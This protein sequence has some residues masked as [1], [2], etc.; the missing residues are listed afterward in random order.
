MTF[1][2]ASV[3]KRPGITRIPGTD[4]A[5]LPQWDKFDSIKENLIPR[6][7]WLMKKSQNSCKQK[8]KVRVSK[9]CWRQRRPYFY[10]W[11]RCFR[12][13]RQSP[14]WLY[15]D[16]HQHH[17]IA[18]HRQWPRKPKT[19]SDGG[20][21]PAKQSSNYPRWNDLTVWQFRYCNRNCFKL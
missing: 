1:C 18:L 11:I 21:K 3:R 19:T 2:S 20:G 12:F 5:Q 8:R 14:L 6:Q 7:K 16:N 10:Q 9:S 4:L 17:K 15:W 13:L